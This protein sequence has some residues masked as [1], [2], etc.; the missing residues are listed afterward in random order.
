MRNDSEIRWLVIVC[1]AVTIW[2]AIQPADYAT[3]FFELFI[4]AGGVGL[5]LLTHARFRF[6]PV[7]YLIVGVHYIILACGAKYTYAEMP[8]FE[9]LK[10]VLHLSRNHFDRVGHFAQ[11]VTPAIVVRELLIRETRLDTAWLRNALA[12]AAALAFSA[13]YEILEWLW[14]ILFYPTQGPEWLGMQGDPWDAQADMLMALLGALAGILLIGRIQDAQLRKR[15]SAAV[16]APQP[17]DAD[18][19]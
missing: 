13:V 19:L 18:R 7:V 14:V 3:W 11:G 10:D 12:F 16:D 15:V 1:I 5:L 9:W 8:V 6:S 4:G 2:S 17:V